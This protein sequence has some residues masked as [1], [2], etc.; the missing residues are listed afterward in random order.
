MFGSL[1]SNPAAEL[2]RVLARAALAA[3]DYKTA[4]LEAGTA[5]KLFRSA[6]MLAVVEMLLLADIYEQTGRHKQA[7]KSIQEYAETSIAGLGE[8]KA[9]LSRHAKI[10]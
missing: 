10:C 9:M 8:D 3:R 6:N 4:E 1:S 5:Y 2:H 7:V